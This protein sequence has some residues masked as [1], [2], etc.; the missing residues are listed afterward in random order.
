MLVVWCKNIWPCIQS[1]LQ[2][3]SLAGVDSWGLVTKSFA[4]IN[5]SDLLTESFTVIHPFSSYRWVLGLRT[6]DLDSWSWSFICN[7]I[8]SVH[9]LKQASQE[10]C[11]QLCF[12]S[13][14]F[15]VIFNALSAS[16]DVE[17]FHPPIFL[18]WCLQ[19]TA[20]WWTPFIKISLNK[21]HVPS[22]SLGNWA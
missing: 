21:K 22:S 19:S 11:G 7:I 2:C 1:F 13:I 8:I 15:L 16:S 9:R 18:V 14:A 10:W 12:L 20:G 3:W 6:T 5:S 17:G 4:G